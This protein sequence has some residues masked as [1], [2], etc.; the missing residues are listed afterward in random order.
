MRQ[1]S[2]AFADGVGGGAPRGR[3]R[4]RAR[5][6][7]RGSPIAPADV[8]GTW[9]EES[10]AVAGR[11]ARAFQRAFTVG[12]KLWVARP[13][14]VARRPV[15]AVVIDPG[16]AFGTDRTRT[17]L[18]CL[19]LLEQP[20]GPMLI[21]AAAP[22]LLAIAA[23]RLGHAPVLACDD[24][25]IAV[26]VAAGERSG[27]G[28]AIQVWQCDA[29]YDEVSKAIPLWAREP[30]ARTAAGARLAPRPAAA[31]LIVSACSRARPSRFRD[32]S[33]RGALEHGRELLLEREAAA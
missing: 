26:E 7:L 23:A 25:P 30:A 27:N 14:R 10:V 31:P 3:R 29:L 21:S 32:T 33:D 8:A 16:Q 17:T 2:E 6:V 15:F 28:A 13:R 22:A 4:T 12:G 11:T 24:D 9:S 20:P 5:G 19:L 18:L 1:C